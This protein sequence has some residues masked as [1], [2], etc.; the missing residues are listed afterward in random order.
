MSL[1]VLVRVVSP[2]NECFLSAFRRT[3]LF[4]YWKNT[5]E[6]TCV[7]N[8]DCTPYNKKYSVFWNLNCTMSLL[9]LFVLGEFLF[10]SFPLHWHS[11]FPPS[12]SPPQRRLLGSPLC[13]ASPPCS[14]RPSH[15][16]WNGSWYLSLWGLSLGVDVFLLIVIQELQGQWL[17]M[18]LNLSVLSLQIRCLCARSPFKKLFDYEIC[19]TC[20]PCTD[21]IDKKPLIWKHCAVQKL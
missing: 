8:N 13:P 19:L 11:L 17:I 6:I 2:I 14:R 20:R 21:K 3:Y 5:V 4:T 18:V 12:G 15:G 16:M 9:I 1:S 7:F 10:F